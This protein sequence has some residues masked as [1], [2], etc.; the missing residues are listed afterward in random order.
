MLFPQLALNK[1]TF[2]TEDEHLSDY[3]FQ[4]DNFLCGLA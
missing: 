3:N 4:N 1:A 2:F